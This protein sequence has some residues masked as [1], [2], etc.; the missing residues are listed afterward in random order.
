MD[1]MLIYPPIGVE[2]RYARKVGKKIGGDLPPL[3]I[4][5]LAAFVREHGFEADVVDS[6]AL[7]MDNGTIL[8]R[9]T[10]KKPKV[11]GFSSL[12]INFHRAVACAKLVR[13]K[14]P[15]ILILVGGHHST[16]LPK[17]VLVEN[18]CIDLSVVGEGEL[19]LLDIMTK[20]KEVQYRRA[21]FLTDTQRLSTINGI[22]F[23]DGSRVTLNPSREVIHDLDILPYPAWDL[24][25]MHLYMPLPNQY[26]RSPVVHMTAIRGCPFKCS[27]CSNN[28]IFGRKIR[29]KSPK[30]VVEEIQYVMKTYGAREISFWD[31]TMTC[32]NQWMTEFC[33]ELIRQKVDI[34]WTGYSRVDTVTPELLKKMKAAGCWN[35]FFG[36]ETGNQELLDI[37]CKG[38]RLDEI[39]QA[40]QWTKDAGIEIRGS[41]MIALPGETPAL[42]QKTIDFAIELDPDYAQFSITTPYPGTQLW[43][44]AQKYGALDKDFSKYHMWTPVFIPFG[45]RDANEILQMEKK[46]IRQFYLRPSFI[47]RSIRKIKTWEDVVRY[48]KGF[49]VLLGF[50]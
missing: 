32:N 44:D 10:E 50:V 3:G 28:A 25:P 2:E 7:D 37:I 27:F 48:M 47:W 14:F 5:C 1:I 26:L 22:A 18:E 34:T 33:D 31:D 21:T 15:E 23:R 29:A 12:T 17:D 42:A 45:Y 49:R 39:R 35:L 6:I 16:I 46:A 13:E 11:V 41:F 43:H 20:F 36:Y 9:I 24:L 38:T 8:Q 4:A 40:N 19:T 30:R